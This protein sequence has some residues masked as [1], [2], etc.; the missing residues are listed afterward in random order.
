MPRRAAQQWTGAGGGSSGPRRR[1]FLNTRTDAAAAR[2]RCPGVGPHATAAPLAYIATQL[3]H[4]R[5]LG[6]GRRPRVQHKTWFLESVA[7]DGSHVTHVLQ[8][9]P[10]SIGRDP[11][12]ALVVDG[13]GLSRRHAELD[14]GPDGRLWLTDLD[15]TNGSFVN[16]E[17]IVGRVAVDEGDVL[18]FGHAEYRLG[19]DTATRIVT[20]QTDN[21]RTQ[22][23]SPGRTLPEHFVR[24]ERPFMEFLGGRGLTAAAQPIVAAEGGDVFAYELLGRAAHP[25]LPGSPMQLF[26]LAKVLQREAELSEAF[27]NHGVRALAPRLNGRRLFVNTHPSETFAEAFF[28]ALQGLVALPDAPALVVE[29]HETAVVDIPRMRAFAARLGE[30]G[31]PF[32]YDDFGAGE[33]RIRELTQVPPHFVK[34]DMGLIRGLD[35]APRV[36]QRLVRDLVRAVVDL[37]SVPLAEGVETEGEAAICR[38]MGFQ[39]IQGYLTG[40]PRPVAEV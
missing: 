15:S 6:G 20:A 22:L 28:T 30:I 19:A 23:V 18:H 11:S 31:V 29:V 34:F 17:R 21:E 9:W 35:A 7:A 36:T 12:N 4:H 33:S 38:D 24:Q 1:D 10:F 27:R 32:A 5:C 8:A 37:G 25:D 3:G 40:K 16:R 26:H 14:V 39:L 13:R 2:H